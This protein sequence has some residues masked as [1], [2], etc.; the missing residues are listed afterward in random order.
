MFN[1]NKYLEKIN[2]PNCSSKDFQV[3]KKANYSKINSYEDLLSIYKSS[4]DELLLDQ[5]SKCTNCNLVYLNPRIKSEIINKSYSENIDD[6]HTNQDIERYK[7][8]K[9]SLSKIICRNKISNF[10]G[11]KF[12]DIGSAS[13]VFL[14][15]LKDIGFQEEGYEPSKWMTKYGK[16]NYNV[17]IKNGSINDVEK[18]KKFEFISFWDVLEHVTNLQS[19]IDKIDNL[20]YKNTIL[21]INVPAIDTL[22]CKILKNKWPFYLNVHLY[23]FTSKTLQEILKKKNFI[24]IDKFP[25]LQVL[26]LEYL[27]LRASKYF[28]FFKIFHFIVK[29]T[30]LAKFSIQY[31]IGQTTFVFK[32]NVL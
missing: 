15:V 28:K 16:Q 8:F 5:L 22:A 7:T 10:L 26:N 23:Y 17:N 12:L 3:L 25:H 2:C 9:K 19:T 24:L 31:N 14:K 32:K 11:K 1:I 21:I 29:N 4:A 27:L 6:Q 20:S 18:K 30:F 13:G